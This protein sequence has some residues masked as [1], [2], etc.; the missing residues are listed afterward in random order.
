[1]RNLKFVFRLGLIGAVLLMAGTGAHAQGV[2]SDAWLDQNE[3]IWTEVTGY[4]YFTRVQNRFLNS[5]LNAVVLRQRRFQNDV[6]EASLKA[7]A[8]DA[9]HGTSC[10]FVQSTAAS[11]SPPGICWAGQ[12][13]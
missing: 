8:E 1:M 11:F 13:A 12:E 10:K 3:D 9:S 7:V 4:Y 6:A 5:T 2:Y